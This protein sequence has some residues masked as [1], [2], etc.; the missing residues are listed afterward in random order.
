MRPPVH[1][2]AAVLLVT[3]VTAAAAAATRAG[4]A[5]EDTPLAGEIRVRVR[6]GGSYARMDGDS[7]AVLRLLRCP[8]A[9]RGD[10]GR[11]QVSNPAGRTV[12]RN[13]SGDRLEIPAG[14]GPAGMAVAITRRP[15]LPFRSVEVTADAAVTR[16]ILTM[17]VTGCESA[18][19]TTVVLW[20]GGDRWDDVGGTLYGTA[21]TAE[22]PHLSI[23][24]IA[25]N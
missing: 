2:L 13:A 6:P 3:F 15:G 20:G 21:L 23:Y 12:A 17:D 16:A 18:P 25:G 10:H 14:G 5:P 11:S 7:V 8:P 22:L 9:A 1:R 24:A 19:G 4:S